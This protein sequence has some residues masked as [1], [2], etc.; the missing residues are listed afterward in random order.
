[1]FCTAPNELGKSSLVNAIR[2]ALLLQSTSAAAAPLRE[3]HADAPPRV[4]LTFEQEAQRVWRVRKSFVSSGHAY[5]ELSRDGS[6]FTQEGK[7][8]EVDGTLRR[9]LRWGLKGPGLPGGKHGMEGR[10]GAG[11]GQAGRGDRGARS[12]RRQAGDGARGE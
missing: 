4:A 6:E 5:L 10:A 9:I 1:M 12:R 11:T 3:W 2:A 8:R 7:G